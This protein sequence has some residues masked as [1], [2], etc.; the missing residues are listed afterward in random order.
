M[1]LIDLRIFFVHFC[2]LLSRIPAETDIF[3]ASIGFAVA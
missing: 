2:Q 3:V 1:N